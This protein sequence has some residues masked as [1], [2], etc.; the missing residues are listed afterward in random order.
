MK[1]GLGFAALATSKAP[2]TPS[3]RIP[4]SPPQHMMQCDATLPLRSREKLLLRSLDTSHVV[5]KMGRGA[6]A[7]TTTLQWEW[8]LSAFQARLSPL[9]LNLILALTLTLTLTLILTLAFTLTL[10]PTLLPP[11]P[12]RRSAWRSACSTTASGWA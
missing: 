3:P 7:G 5:L 6:D 2:H 12:R 8:P 10:T 9:S 4:A 1:L 11:L